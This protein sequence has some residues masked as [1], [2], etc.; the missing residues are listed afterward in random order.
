[1]SSLKLTK[2]DQRNGFQ[3]DFSLSGDNDNC[4]LGLE[5]KG[6]CHKSARVILF[7]SWPWCLL[8]LSSEKV[9]TQQLE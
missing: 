3:T 7:Q 8:P 9:M 4:L 5:E 2:S 1:M 6:V